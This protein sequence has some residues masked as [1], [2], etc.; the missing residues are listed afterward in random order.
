MNCLSC[1]YEH[2]EKYCPNCGEKSEVK[3]I[4]FTGVFE[5]AFST[6]T[7]MD[8]GL[9]YNIKNLTTN[10]NQI[11]T[12]YIHGKRRNILNPISFLLISIAIYLLA[13]SAFKNLVDQN[14]ADPENDIASIGYKAGRFIR[15]YFNY[16]WGFSVFWLS[17]STKIIFGK[18]NFAEHLT[19]SSFIVALATLIGILSYLV[20]QLPVMFDPLVYLIILIMIY[21][22]FK[23][24]DDKIVVFIKS[25]FAI[26]LFFIFI[27]IVTISIGYIINKYQ[28]LQL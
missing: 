20:W 10:P 1:N 6:I 8:K 3:K 26:I 25:A 27:F 15:G 14:F 12:S 19:I 13:G 4:T 23:N 24:E 5:D 2:T 22:V 16:F 18:Y 21:Q 28:S 7:N 17:I 9:L 11:I